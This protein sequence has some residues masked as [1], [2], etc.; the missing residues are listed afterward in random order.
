MT[1]VV[2]ICILGFGIILAHSQRDRFLGR[3]LAHFLTSAFVIPCRQGS[4][5]AL[6]GSTHGQRRRAQQVSGDLTFG[7]WDHALNRV[8]E[9]L[10]ADF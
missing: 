3:C 4:D 10:A 5:S 6:W 8:A 2:G 7:E 1:S 9:I